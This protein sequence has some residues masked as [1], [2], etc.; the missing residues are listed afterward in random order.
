MKRVPLLPAGPVRSRT[1]GLTALCLGPSSL[2][3][4]LALSPSPAGTVCGVRGAAG[5]VSAASEGRHPVLTLSPLS[6]LGQS[7]G[8][9][10]RLASCPP[11][12]RG[13]ILYCTT[14]VLLARLRRQPRL[15]PVTHLVIDEVSG[16]SQMPVIMISV[17]FFCKCTSRNKEA[18]IQPWR[19]LAF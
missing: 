18:D 17:V 2:T 19:C 8:Y 11:R 14:G 6:Q 3:H 13:G 15:D 16:S 1:L 10:V 9:A 5:L 7:V 4:E 12:Q